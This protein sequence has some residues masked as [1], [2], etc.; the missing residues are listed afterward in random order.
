[1][2]LSKFNHKNIVKYY[3]FLEIDII[4]R[5]K[6]NAYWKNIYI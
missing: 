6:K 2:V 3:D 4:K 1:M 5:L